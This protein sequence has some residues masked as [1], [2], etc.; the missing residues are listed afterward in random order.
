MIVEHGFRRFDLAASSYDRRTRIPPAK[1]EEIARAVVSLSRA[2]RGEALL[3]LGAGTGQI[4]IFFPET[5]V[6]YTGL[7][8]SKERCGNH[9]DRYELV[10]SDVNQSWPVSDASVR[11][12]F[13]SRAVHLFDKEN[14]LRE[15]R[16][17]ALETGAALVVGR[18][19]R[20]PN[21]VRQ[22]LKLEKR[23]QLAERGFL[24]VD[25]EGRQRNLLAQAR[26]Q[27]AEPFAAKVAATW[28]VRHRAGDVLSDWSETPGLGGSSLPAGVKQELLADLRRFAQLR[29]GSLDTFHESEDRY[30]LEGVWF[31]R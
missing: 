21:S 14:V 15:A 12:I 3:E 10:H 1:C 5:G 27:G 13:S 29:F 23:A 25:G 28:Q 7:D 16:R 2:E 22:Q 30:V 18:V 19:E 11:C 20:D 31:R 4:G 17:V 6:R 9:A 26:A 24:A 8:V